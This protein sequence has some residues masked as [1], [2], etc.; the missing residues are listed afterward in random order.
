MGSVYSLVGGEREGVS[1]LASNS[2][3]NVQ[4]VIV[5]LCLILPWEL[6]SSDL[7]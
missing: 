3:H 1:E 2:R 6:L 7:E 5:I 4:Q